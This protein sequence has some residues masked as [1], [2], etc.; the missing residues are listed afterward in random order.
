MTTEQQI[1]EL[2][3]IEAMGALMISRSSKLRINLEKESK[4]VVKK[5]PINEALKA[6]FKLTRMKRQQAA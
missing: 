1:K 4:V 5:K 2:L 6:K 3:E